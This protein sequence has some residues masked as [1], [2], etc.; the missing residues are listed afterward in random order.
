[1]DFTL[2][3]QYLLR[4]RKNGSFFMYH[5]A[6]NKRYEITEK[7]FK[8][9]Y[10]FK[11]RSIDLNNLLAFFRSNDIAT[12]DIEDFLSRPDMTD[13]LINEKP[14]Y[15]NTHPLNI[16]STDDKLP[17]YTEYT[18]ER[19]DF[20]ITKQ[21]NLKCKHCF[22]EAS[23]K[24]QSNPIDLT[25]LYN[26]FA[27]MDELDVKT[28]KITGG[29][30]LVHPQISSILDKLSEVRFETILLTNGMLLN[31]RTINQIKEADIKLG[32]SL[33]GISAQTH[34]FLR[35]KGTFELLMSKLHLLEKAKADLSLTFTAN[36][37]NYSELEK[38]VQ[39]AFT[40][41]NVRCIFINRL[42]PMG[43]AAND[44]GL[45]LSEEE[46][47]KMVEKISL[48]SVQYGDDKIS[49]SDDALT[50]VHYDLENK[51]LTDFPLVCAAGNTILSF[52]DNFNVYPCIYGHNNVSFTIGNLSK[53]KLIDIWR[54]EKWQP[55][56][57]GT[58]LSQIR[59]C[60]SCI[61][62][63]NCGIKNCRMKPVFNGLSFFDH[64]EYCSM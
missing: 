48:L 34:D 9:L 21:C 3:Q 42:R 12:D 32:I 8:F 25:L 43:R 52:D 50:T 49:L 31:D 51:P 37:I 10:I 61:K 56:R 46:Y 57:G 18:P 33:D 27:Q 1:M 28:L 7:L 63:S 55:F 6:N 2:S 29:E 58:S 16:Y 40:K 44:E 45:F 15:L 23:P 53:E 62:K 26:I 30:P 20:L 22:E 54:S 59:G 14:A 35:G 60:N 4:K 11:D 19:I 36:K 39:Y 5:K 38:L 64:A 24:L 13:I 17:A 47:K 41:L